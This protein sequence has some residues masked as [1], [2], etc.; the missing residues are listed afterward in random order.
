MSAQP[1][2]RTIRVERDVPEP[3]VFV[4]CTRCAAEG[5]SDRGVWTPLDEADQ[6]ATDEVHRGRVVTLEP[7]VD[8]HVDCLTILEVRH[9]PAT[10]PMR[11]EAAER[12]AEIYDEV[13]TEL[14]GA[15]CAWIEA[16]V[17]VEDGDDLPSAGDF[18]ER[19]CGT[20]PDFESYA[21]QLI[22]DSG[23]QQGW[24]EQAVRY[25]DISRWARDERANYTVLEVPNGGVYVFRDL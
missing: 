24:P 11:I 25:F 7:G 5:R 1:W 13:G 6:V 2:A 14:W 4:G 12:W 19:Y 9:L 3:T 22:E 8:L 16:G 15:F 21:A 18:T 23:S 10:A 17:Q 20:W